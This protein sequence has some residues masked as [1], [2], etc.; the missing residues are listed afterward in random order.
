MIDFMADFPIEA[1]RIAEQQITSIY[2]IIDL[3]L[4]YCLKAS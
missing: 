4:F 3:L 2:D 1:L